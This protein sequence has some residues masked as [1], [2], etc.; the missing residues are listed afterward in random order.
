MGKKIIALDAGHGMN[1]SGKRITLSGYEPTREW[2]LNDRIADK[3]QA[4]LTEKYECT[5]LRVDDTTGAKDIPMAT[6]VKTANNAGADFYMS[7]HHNAGVNGGMGGGTVVFYWASVK[8]RDMAQRLY[9]FV[10]DETKL[11]GNRCERVGKKAFYVIKNTKM[12]A[13]L[14]ENGF[15]DS[16]VDVPI[17][18]T[19]AHAE[20]TAKGIVAFLVKELSLEPKKGAETGTESVTEASVYYPK[21]MGAKTTLYS[22]MKSL[23]IDPSFKHRKAIAKENGIAGY[24]GSAK[25]NTQMYNLLVAGLLV[26]A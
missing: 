22:A 16:R 23:G 12:P 17:I 1:T 7:I 19:K 20:K 25:Q 21:Y 14:I 8:M 2:W 13:L 11:Y 6:R 5:V 9:N 24:I 15:M 4:E 3:V 18:L 26:I 10:T